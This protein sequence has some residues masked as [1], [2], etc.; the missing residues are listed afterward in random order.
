MDLVHPGAIPAAALQLE[1][2]TWRLFGWAAHASATNRFSTWSAS[3]LVPEGPWTL[4]G[5][6][7]VDTGQPGAWDSEL[8][9]AGSVLPT[10]EGYALWYEGEGAGTSVRGD[11]GLATSADGV[12]WQKA[13]DPVIR[14]GICGAGTAAA[15]EQPQVEAWS[16][17]FVGA[18]GAAAVGD[19]GMSVFGVTSADGRS[20]ACGGAEPLLRAADIPGGHGIHTIASLPLD[21]DRFELIIESLLDGRSELWSAVVEVGG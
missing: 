16:G 4:V 2:G 3:A 12:A 14:R 10:S 9:E 7:V 11:I 1:D 18:V 19:R 20:W 6:H 8:A 17:G 15:V 21:G 13:D 5:E